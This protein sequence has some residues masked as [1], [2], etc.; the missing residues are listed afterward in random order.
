M[1]SVA[2][3]QGYEAAHSS[4]KYWNPFPLGSA[5]FNDF[6]AGFFA[7]R[8]RGIRPLGAMALAL[9]RARRD[10]RQGEDS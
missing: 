7:A 3:R 4:L 6:E 8:K 1:Q 2:Y 10:R 5:K 9:F